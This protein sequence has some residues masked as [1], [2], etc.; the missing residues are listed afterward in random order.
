M[1]TLTLN[2]GSRWAV[3]VAH[4]TGVRQ[5]AR[6]AVVAT[7]DGDGETVRETFDEVLALHAAAVAPAPSVD[8]EA[9]AL[10]A[11]V[12]RAMGEALFTGRS[13]ARAAVDHALG[14][15]AGCVW[16]DTMEALHALANRLASR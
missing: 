4:I 16:S 11:R 7:A 15:G 3:P 6:G 13:S 5:H 10:A 8:R 12:V 14:L 1:I 2:N 9:V